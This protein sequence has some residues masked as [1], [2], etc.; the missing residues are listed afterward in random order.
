MK[1]TECG[2]GSQ[3]VT[4]LGDSRKGPPPWGTSRVAAHL[5]LELVNELLETVDLEPPMHLGF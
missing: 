3:C 2:Q 5:T 4:G 1:D